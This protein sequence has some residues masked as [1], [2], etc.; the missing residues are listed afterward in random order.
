LYIVKAKENSK[1]IVWQII[2]VDGEWCGSLGVR[3]GKAK[4]MK[5]VQME[6]I[7]GYG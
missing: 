5:I 3:K 1:V 2:T 6:M 7:C 4:E